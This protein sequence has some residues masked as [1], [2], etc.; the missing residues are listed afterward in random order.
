MS[1]LTKDSFSLLFYPCAIFFLNWDKFPCNLFLICLAEFS[2]SQ[3]VLKCRFYGNSLAIQW[4]GLLG[5]TAVG[6]GSIPGPRIKILQATWWLRW[7]RIC[8]QCGRPEFHPWVWKIPCRREWQP[9]PVLLPGES[10]RTE[11]PGG[12]Q[13]I[14]L[15]RV[16]HNWTTF[17]FVAKNN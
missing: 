13:F 8:L 2:H 3:G 15:Q 14:G 11:E 5:F 1:F 16:G 6:L 12:I 10:P 17:S 4:L 7:L 9:P